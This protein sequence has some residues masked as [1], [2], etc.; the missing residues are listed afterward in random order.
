MRSYNFT[1]RMRKV[2]ALAREEANR[3]RHEY[4]GTE[5]VLLGLLREGGGVAGEAL[6][7]LAIDPETIRTRVTEIVREGKAARATLELPYTTRSKKVLELAMDEAAQLG[8]PYVGTEHLLLGLIREEKGVAAQVLLSVGL[9]LE[10]VRA[11]VLRL[12]GTE[13]PGEGKVDTTRT[14]EGIR[15]RAIQ[16]RVDWEDGRWF[17]QQFRT[18]ANAIAFLESLPESGPSNGVD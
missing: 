6:R 10:S 1:E 8:H 3:L 15:P 7:S 14:R 9:T 18:A 2:L 16:I 11:E 13:L 4:V 5:H 17:E 12:L